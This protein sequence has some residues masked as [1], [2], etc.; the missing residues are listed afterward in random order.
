MN[1]NVKKVIEIARSWDK[2]SIYGTS[3]CPNETCAFFVRFVFEQALHEAGVMRVAD[4]R[5]YYIENKIPA[6]PTG[7]NFADGLAG[8]LVGPKVSPQQIQAGDL[9][10][11]KDTYND[12][13]F[14]KG[15]I[16]HVGIALD[17]NGMMAD[18]SGG[19]CHVRNY[20]H[21]FPNKLVEVRRPHCLGKMAK[22]VGVTLNKG[23]VLK[24]G[25][26]QEIKVKFGI[27]DRERI[28]QMKKPNSKTYV[29]VDGKNVQYKYITV[30]ITIAGG[31]HIKLFHHDGQ[32]NAYVAD[33][34][35]RFLEVVAKLNGGLHVW[36]DGKEI[37]PSSVNI[38]VS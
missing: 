14:S 15:S 3:G 11:F 27:S 30:D 2:K 17:S 5:P 38:G 28:Y 24:A 20:K 18:S 10:F 37:K 8:D 19:K 26:K 25:C 12:G 7:K 29:S 36:T 21:Y 31:K 4:I 22:G 35:V 9:L 6:L 13:T 1:I 32:T 33:H 16:T 23:Q 34:K